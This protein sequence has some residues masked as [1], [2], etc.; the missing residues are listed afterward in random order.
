[1]KTNLS[2]FALLF[3]LVLSQGC[4][5][6]TNESANDASAISNEAANSERTEKAERIAAKRAELVKVK[7]EKQES[8]KMAAADRAAK[9][10][11]YKNASGRVV[12]YTVETEPYYSGGESAMN[13]YLSD[14]LKY[15]QE[16]LDNEIEGTVYVDFIVNEDGMVSEITATDFVGDIDQTLKDEAVR[17]VSSM[18]AWMAGRQNGKNVNS[19]FSIPI[20]FQINN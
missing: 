4:A 11:S 10:P 18:P 3:A 12:Y 15:P 9:T 17:V 16:A 13:N 8:R 20:T 6:K 7:A 2:F 14:N 1:M 19:A 5:T